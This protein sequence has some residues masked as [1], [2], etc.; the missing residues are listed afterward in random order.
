VCLEKAPDPTRATRPNWT[1]V[2]CIR[3]DSSL[4]SNRRRMTVARG[5]NGAP[6]HGHLRCC[7]GEELLG[8][9][10]RSEAEVSAPDRASGEPGSFSS[11]RLPRIAVSKALT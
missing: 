5:A 3:L 10:P 4:E 2:D 1:P 8:T 11:A 6:A 9:K 7:P